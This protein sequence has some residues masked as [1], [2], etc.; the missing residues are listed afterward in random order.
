MS[1]FTSRKFRV[2][3]LTIFITLFLI[4]ILGITYYFYTRSN[5]A[6]LKVANGFIN[7]TLDSISQKMDEFLKPTPLFSIASLIMNDHQLDLADMNEL[8]SYMHVVLKA[9]PQ[10]VNVYIADTNGN[11]F[12]ENRVNDLPGSDQLIPF[13]DKSKI[14]TGTV[15]V[16]EMLTPEKGR[17]RVKYIFKDR[18]GDAVQ[19]NNTIKPLF[20]PRIRPW[21]T[22]AQKSK[23]KIWIGVYPFYE[24]KSPILTIAF[25][26]YTNGKFM[27]V[28]A[29]DIHLSSVREAM[30]KFSEDTKGIVFIA[31]HHGQFIAYQDDAV[32]LEKQS[33]HASVYTSDNPV[34]KKAYKLHV[35]T[36]AEN[37]TFTLNGVTYVA[38]FKPY[39]VSDA[40]RWEI[41]A[42]IPMDVF[43]GSI[44]SVNK[45]ALIFSLTTLLIGLILVVLSSNRISQPIIKIAEE[46]Q[47]MQHFNFSKTTE[48]KSHIYEVQV[49]VTA[50]NIA[51]TALH[52][53]SKYVPKMIVDQLLRVGTIAEL[54]GEKKKITIMFSDIKN[55]TTISEK[56]DPNLLML[57]LSEYLNVLTKCIHDR[58]GNIDKYIGDAIMAFWGAPNAD[59]HQNENACL[60]LLACQR[61]VLKLNKEFSTLGKPV[62]HTRFGLNTGIATVGN[63][64]S[65]DRLNYTAIGDAVNLAARLEKANKDYSTEIL[66]SESVYAATRDKFL[67]RPVD[68]V[69]VKGKNEFIAIY[70]LVA[71]LHSHD[72][73][74]P[75][76]KQLELC[77][78]FT[79]AY[80]LFHAK[81]YKLSNELLRELSVKFPEDAVIHLYLARCEAHFTNR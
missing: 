53:F 80:R 30:E 7:R 32:D 25:P 18:V 10:L 36:E 35:A 68:I 21:Y 52:S 20:D 48:I 31:N 74:A 51:K 63:L 22:S 4:S 17:S 34:I 8:A 61:A 54:G 11:I 26:I 50:L 2:D 72:E 42:I 56:A 37:F 13:I 45:R 79:D 81:Q 24:M 12:I 1:V 60:A 71:Q 47:D 67:F 28:A 78:L 15:F 65:S 62:F 70:E 29:A 6:I 66:V 44:S 49:M 23:Q 39:S 16:S 43:V 57:Y 5:E 75:T 3:I 27:G 59:T 40:E 38:H 77:R 41:A 76:E 19:D 46:T 58:Q 9:Y 69:Q 14:P 55:F 64:G 33:L 73:F